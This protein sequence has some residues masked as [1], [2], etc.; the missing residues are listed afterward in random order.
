MFDRWASIST[1]QAADYKNRARTALERFYGNAL[2]DKEYTAAVRALDYLCKLD[3]CFAP[4]NVT[5]SGSVGHAVDMR[6]VFGFSPDEARERIRQGVKKHAV[7]TL[8]SISVV[9]AVAVA[10]GGNGSNGAGGNGCG[11][12]S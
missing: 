2:K 4:T 9:P 12:G 11:Q 3:G 5:V 6:G 10:V 7:G 8:P 1:E